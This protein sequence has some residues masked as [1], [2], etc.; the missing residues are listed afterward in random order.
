MYAAEEDTAANDERAFTRKRSAPLVLLA[1]DDED[2]RAAMADALRRIGLRVAAVSDGNAL[3][4]VLGGD[5]ADYEHPDLV[6]TD[7]HMPGCNGVTAL[8]IIHASGMDLPAIVVTGF[9]DEAMRADAQRFGAVAVLQK[10]I[11]LDELRIRI[12]TLLKCA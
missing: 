7:N 11:D 8:E 6:I 4:D 9:R 1:D 3:L 2:F 12:I 10:P 5:D